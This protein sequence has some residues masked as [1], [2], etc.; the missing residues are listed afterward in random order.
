MR[1]FLAALALCCALN[2][3]AQPSR[4]SVLALMSAEDV[5]KALRCPPPL[6]CERRNKFR[7]QKR[8]LR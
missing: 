7:P 8:K 2:A 5:V 4:P 1:A 3:S 6:Q